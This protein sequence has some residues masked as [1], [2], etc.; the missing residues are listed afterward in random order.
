MSTIW[1]NFKYLEQYPNAPMAYLLVQIH[2]KMRQ[3]CM[4]HHPLF[5]SGC[6]S[7]R[8]QNL[9]NIDG[10]V[11][12]NRKNSVSWMFGDGMKRAK[13]GERK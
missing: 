8:P 1:N 6:S 13:K 3:P 10:N 12:T 7:R 5:D 2:A 4:R 9:C 11:K